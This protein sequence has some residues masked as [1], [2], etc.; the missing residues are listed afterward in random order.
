MN[1]EQLTA[2]LAEQVMGWT[3]APGRF[4]LGDRKWIPR[5][6]FQPLSNIEHAFELLEKAASTFKLATAPDGT[7]TARVQVGD[8]IGIASGEPKATSISLAVARAIGLD[9]PDEAVSRS[10]SNGS[11]P[12][13]GEPKR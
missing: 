6:R 13:D 4:L 1:A 10:A 7:F 9:V 2:R 12:K 5:W 3:V 11:R 8:H